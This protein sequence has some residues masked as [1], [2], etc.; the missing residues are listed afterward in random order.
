MIFVLVN[1][2]IDYMQFLTQTDC[3]QFLYATVTIERYA[4]D[5]PRYVFRQVSLKTNDIKWHCA[6]QTAL[7]K[8]AD[9]LFWNM[10]LRDL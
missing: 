8:M 1:K 7:F 2:L 3:M 6:D 9:E 10:I 4:T 5:D